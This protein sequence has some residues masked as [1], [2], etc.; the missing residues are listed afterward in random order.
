MKVSYIVLYLSALSEAVARAA[1]R[2]SD[3]HGRRRP[4]GG[5]GGSQERRS[6]RMRYMAAVA[7]PGSTH[8]LILRASFMNI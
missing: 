1:A 2:A 6:F 8:E 4:G 3:E 7:F 5:A